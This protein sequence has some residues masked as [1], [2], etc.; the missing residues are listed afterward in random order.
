M[1]SLDLT[2]EELRAEH[3]RARKLQS[4]ASDYGAAELV[5][6]YGFLIKSIEFDAANRNITL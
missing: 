5:S 3:L 2:P 6:H 1:E 4:I